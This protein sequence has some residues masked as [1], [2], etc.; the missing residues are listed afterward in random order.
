MSASLSIEISMGWD[1]ADSSSRYVTC[2]LLVTFVA[3]HPFSSV[4]SLLSLP[5]VTVQRS[6]NAMKNHLKKQPRINHDKSVECFRN[7]THTAILPLHTTTT[8]SIELFSFVLRCLSIHLWQQLEAAVVL[9]VALY[10][11][12]ISRGRYLISSG[13]VERWEVR[14]GRGGGWSF[15]VAAY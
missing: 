7:S 11:V 1:V 2:P 13:G 8:T 15:E 10:I 3:C 14:G 9:G 4:P 5:A 12:Q 6:R